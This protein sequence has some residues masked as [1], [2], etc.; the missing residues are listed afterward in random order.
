MGLASQLATAFF[1]FGV[2]VIGSTGTLIVRVI[3]AFGG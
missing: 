1:T 2:E 3:Q